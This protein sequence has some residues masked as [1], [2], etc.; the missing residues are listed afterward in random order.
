MDVLNIPSDSFDY[1]IT[2]ETDSARL[3]QVH[4]QK[5]NVFAEDL[6]IIMFI[7]LRK[8]NKVVGWSNILRRYYFQIEHVH[9]QTLYRYRDRNVCFIIVR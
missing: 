3:T 6:Q 5:Q 7:R 4:C 9:L 2:G 8:N 1:R